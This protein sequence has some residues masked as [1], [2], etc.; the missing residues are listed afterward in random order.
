MIQTCSQQA[1]CSCWQVASPEN[2]I[3]LHSCF[4]MS[5]ICLC[6]C[7]CGTQKRNQKNL[8]NLIDVC[9]KLLYT[10]IFLNF[11]SFF[12]P[13]G[14]KREGTQ[15]ALFDIAGADLGWNPGGPGECAEEQLTG[16]FKTLVPLKILSWDSKPL[17][18]QQSPTGFLQFLI[19]ES[20]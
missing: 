4:E 8:T 5:A 2:C 3:L 18:Q 11:V 12:P 13:K 9:W 20:L 17:T 16:C 10:S 19:G 7:R 15:G 1:R 14:F 6:F